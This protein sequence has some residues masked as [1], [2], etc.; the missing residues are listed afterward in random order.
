MLHQE[1]V[2]KST[3]ELIRQI[4]SDQ[5]FSNFDLAGGTSL[6]LQIGHRKSIDIDLFTKDDFDSQRILEY[7][8]KQYGFKLHYIYQNTLKGIIDNVMVDLIKHDYTLIKDRIIN[9]G[10]RLLSKE[11]IAAMKVNAISGNGSRVKDFI[12]IYFLLKEFSFQ[13]IIEFY[14]NK[15][16]SRSKFHAVKSLGYFDDIIAEDWP[17]MILEQDLTVEKVTSTILE[18]QKDYLDTILK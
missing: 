14:S 6:A 5:W 1:T 12:D 13:D 2:D 3:L 11:D 7:L 15:Y 18:H 16:G 8:E 17:A 9:E 4:Q 10:I